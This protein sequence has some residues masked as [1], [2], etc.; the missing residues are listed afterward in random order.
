MSMSSQKTES[1]ESILQMAGV[2]KSFGATVALA[3]VAIEVQSGSVHA[4][5]GENG[6][7]K[8]T[9]MKILSGAIRPDSGSMAV[10][11]MNYNPR[12]PS[13]ARDRGVAMIYQELMLA[14][15]LN[16]VDNICLGREFRR[17]GFVNK[18]KQKSLV[19]NVLTQ[20]GCEHLDLNAPVSEF[21]VGEQQLLEIARALAY[22]AK[23]VI[24]DEPTSSLTQKDA[25]KLFSVIDDLKDRNI[26]VIYI[27]HFLEEIRRVADRYTVLRDGSLVDS[28]SLDGVTEKEIVHMMV[29]REVDELFPKVDHQIGEPVL[30]LSHLSGIEVPIDVSFQ[31]RKGEVLGFSGLVGA[32]RTELMRAIYGLDAIQ[33][34]RI[35]IAG[36]AL[37]RT[38]P[39][40]SIAN[41]LAMISEDRKTEGLAQDQSIGENITYSKLSPYS[42][43][44]ILNLPKRR[45]A[46]SKW[47]KEVEIKASSQ[48]A[49]VSSLSGGNQQK[50]AIA[51]VL[52]QD[53][54]I[55]LLDEPTRGIDVGTK[56]EVYRIIGEL[57]A[58]G[59][60]VV[61]VSSYLPELMAI[62]DRIAV[63]A[64][65]RIREIK[66]VTQWT[67]HDIMMHAVTTEN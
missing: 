15:H 17:F 65:G 24:F 25:Q 38:N 34:G 53:A 45:Q 32:G 48:D 62:C 11:G 33:S 66:D 51:R 4:L 56:S 10:S 40:K 29:G 37:T 22:D 36:K 7:G 6:A 1:D 63:M 42:K 30:E 19:K 23:I 57:A 47:M 64:R 67:E 27:S 44:G 20:L 14:P 49:A 8:S 35:S 26:A 61:V 50:V 3:N 2:S 28:G 54:D 13:Q 5:I 21:S 43:A 12:T 46:V 9:L 18:A 58:E 16:A 41:G 39:R 60:S 52:H 31:L 55:Y 59:K